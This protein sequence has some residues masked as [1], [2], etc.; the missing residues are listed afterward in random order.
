MISSL[1]GTKPARRSTPCE[2][3]FEMAY[4]RRRALSVFFLQL[5]ETACRRKAGTCYLR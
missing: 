3:T 4:G 2:A 5:S 1:R